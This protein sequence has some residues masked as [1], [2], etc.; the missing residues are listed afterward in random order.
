MSGQWGYICRGCQTT[1]DSD[2]NRVPVDKQRNN[3][4]RESAETLAKIHEIK[5][6]HKPEIIG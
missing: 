5:T 4:S 1:T 6:G 2:G 3:L